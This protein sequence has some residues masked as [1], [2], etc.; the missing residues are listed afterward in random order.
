M[1]KIKMDI[2]RKYQIKRNLTIRDIMG[3]LLS[4][5]EEINIEVPELWPGKKSFEVLAIDSRGSDSTRK[6]HVWKSL[7]FIRLL[8]IYPSLTIEF[9]IKTDNAQLVRDC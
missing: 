3:S 9:N 8:H 5:G 1:D 2:G 7:F 6:D 4:P